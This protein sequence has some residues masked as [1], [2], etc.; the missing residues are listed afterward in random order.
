MFRIP[1]IAAISFRLDC[2][3]GSPT[4]PVEACVAA[5]PLDQRGRRPRFVREFL[6][7]S[8]VTLS[9]YVTARRSILPGA[10]GEVTGA[11]FARRGVAVRGGAGVIADTRAA[12]G[13]ER[14]ERASA[15]SKRDKRRSG[16]FIGR[17][18]KREIKKKRSGERSGWR[19]AR[20]GAADTLSRWREI[21][22][23]EASHYFKRGP[24]SLYLRPVPP[25]PVP[26]FAPFLPVRLSL[27]SLFPFR[28][29]WFSGGR[30]AG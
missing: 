27:F 3:I 2:S 13:S 17:G 10:A 26:F 15:R 24:P 9:R 19:S 23:K 21:R 12:G 7:A 29:R 22:I 11:G 8:R 14:A 16:S 28:R 18:G 5:G 4:W 6:A 25:R 20:A 30:A 1:R